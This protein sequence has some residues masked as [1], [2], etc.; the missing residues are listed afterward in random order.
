MKNFFIT[1]AS[2]ISLNVS[3][4]SSIWATA[5][6]ISA[7]QKTSEFQ[8]FIRESDSDFVIQKAFPSSRNRELLSVYEI[9]CNRCDEV[10][11][12]AA[13]HKVPG[14]TGIEY[15]PQYETLQAPNDYYLTFSNNW[16]LDLINAQ[17]AWTY[18]TGNPL[19]NVAVSDQNYYSNHEELNGKINYYDATNTATKTHGTAVANIIAGNTNNGIGTAAIGYNTT[20][21]LYRMNYNEALMASNAGARVINLSWA[22]GCTYN[23]YAQAVIDEIWA[24]G[25]FIVAA[26]G[27]GSTC[28]NPDALVYPAAYNHVFAVTSVG[29]QD[30][31]E[32]TVGNPNTRHQTNSSV[33]ICAPGHNVPITAAPGWYL[34]SSGTSFA[35]PY[36]TGTVALMIAHK[37]D[38]TNNEIDSI[39]RASAV[40]INTINPAY[41]GKIGA[42][43]LNA[44][45]ALRMVQNLIDLE[46]AA[47]NDGN[48]GHGND[49]DGNDSSNPGQGGNNGNNGNNGNAG[50]NGNHYGWDKGQ[51]RLSESVNQTVLDMAGKVVNLE[52]ALPGF[53]FIIENGKSTR[54]YK[55]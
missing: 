48:N 29:S 46:A 18:T 15:A 45:E 55:N 43:R 21:N 32:R 30:N 41:V 25:T 35:T 37:D 14:L 28:G 8:A 13:M 34:Y 19:L 17:T 22:S 12:Y 3:A 42:G 50:G 23:S 40:N 24:N 27:N 49:A 39:L 54:I 47:N 52:Y 26:A 44:G 9:Q 51:K 31:I 4:Q 36:V 11:L 2:L 10:D 20:L 5:T 53:Y 7:V 1:I 16:A 38:I 6:D 33:D